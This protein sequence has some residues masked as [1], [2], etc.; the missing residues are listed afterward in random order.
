MFQIY[1]ETLGF[2][3]NLPIKLAFFGCEIIMKSFMEPY[4]IRKILVIKK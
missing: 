1:M 3:F 4:Q 2:M